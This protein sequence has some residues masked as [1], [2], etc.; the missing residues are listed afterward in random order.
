M[1]TLTNS[2]YE[3]DFF[4]WTQQQ[5]KLIKEKAFNKLDLLHL[6]EEL[7]LMGASERRELSH[8]L[9]I[10]LMH[11]LKWKYQ[12]SRQCKSWERTIKIQRLDLIDHLDQNPSLKAQTQEYIAKVYEKAL[13]MAAE[14]TGLEEKTF[15]GKCDWSIEEILNNNF[16]PN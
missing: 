7:H 16:F 9:E 6:Q 4:A 1:S 11:L 2:L 13:I 12:P 8:R 14:E 15:P 5:A 10:L 3:R